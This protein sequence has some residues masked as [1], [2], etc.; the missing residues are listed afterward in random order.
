VYLTDGT[1]LFR[2]DLAANSITKVGDFNCL[3]TANGS[4]SMSWLALDS[5]GNLLG[6]TYKFY[7]PGQGSSALVH[8]DRTNATCSFIHWDPMSDYPIGSFMPVGV[9]DPQKEALVGMTNGAYVRIDP[10]TGD[11]TQLGDFAGSGQQTTYLPEGGMAAAAGKTYTRCW[12]YNSTQTD[13]EIHLAEYN[14]TSGH[15][16]RV[17]NINNFPA[18]SYTLVRQGA[19]LYTIGSDTGTPMAKI[20]LSTETLTTIPTPTGGAGLQIVA[21]TAAPMAP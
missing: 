18:H 21:A 3:Q 17:L 1:S 10:T 4:H 14:P 2:L 19:F 13:V 15:L 5:A 8:I 6:T 20:D 12:S 7:P 9:V 11:V 16:V